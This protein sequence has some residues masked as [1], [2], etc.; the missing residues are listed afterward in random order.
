MNACVERNNNLVVSSAGQFVH[1]VLQV[2]VW[3]AVGHV[4]FSL[5]MLV[6]QCR[7]RFPQTRSM[8]IHIVRQAA[9]CDREG[10]AR[11]DLQVLWRSNDGASLHV[12]QT[13]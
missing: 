3:L 9:V 2:K 13:V 8:T 1:D 7:C 11:V 10:L 12:F 4:Y 6:D 5:T